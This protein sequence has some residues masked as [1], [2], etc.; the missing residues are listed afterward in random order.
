M[1]AVSTLQA[2]DA[3]AALKSLSGLNM[4]HPTVL[5]AVKSMVGTMDDQADT[6]IVML[7][8]PAGVGKSFATERLATKMESMYA[9][10]T[11]AFPNARPAVVLDT[12]EAGDR[13]FSFKT[14]Y[15]DILAALGGPPLIGRRPEPLP[16]DTEVGGRGQSIAALR[17]AV[18]EALKARQT[19]MLVLDEAAHMLSVRNSER[20]HRNAMTLKS[21]ANKRQA[22]LVLAC[23]YDGLPFLEVDS[24]LTRR[25]DVVHLPRYRDDIADDVQ[26]YRNCVMTIGQ[27]IGLDLDHLDAHVEPLMER[28]VGCVGS[29]MKAFRKCCSLHKEAKAEAFD[30]AL[31]E[32]AWPTKNS[33]RKL[34]SEILEAERYLADA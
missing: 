9:P 18:L 14:L 26:A 24:Q 32:A 17:R 5:Q 3:A 4:P 15:I 27:R 8:G 1:Y 29:T 12:P 16:W 10:V 34:R 7:V 22:V 30:F 13:E 31:L 23:A 6:Q 25:I 2:F 33:A 21:I 28:T 19:Q 20:L 11:S